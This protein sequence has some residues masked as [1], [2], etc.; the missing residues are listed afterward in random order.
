MPISSAVNPYS[1]QWI[2]NNLTKM[3]NR[4]YS[5]EGRWELENELLEE[6]WPWLTKTAEQLA[7]MAPP[8][9]DRESI[10]GEIL[11]E[12]Y[13]AIRRIDWSRYDCWPSLLKS[14]IRGAF[15]S[16]A[17]SE[18]PL[19]R[20]Q[21]AARKKFLAA[22]QEFIQREQRSLTWRERRDLARSFAPQGGLSATLYGGA[23][24]KVDADWE[25]IAEGRA[26]EEPMPEI[27]ATAREERRV[28]MEWLMNDVPSTLRN[29]LIEWMGAGGVTIPVNK[30]K[31]VLPYLEKLEMRLAG[32]GR[33]SAAEGGASAVPNYPASEVV[34]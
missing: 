17:R 9:A 5:G 13:A 30:R 4:Y 18:D 10:K 23:Y 2:L 31:Q 1:K 8:R 16:V 25:G 26:D 24:I 19:T 22:E 14:H 7:S 6:L 20:G 11:F 21:R 27:Q 33:P 28:I 15:T 34:P 32:D 3:A 12:A 29:Y